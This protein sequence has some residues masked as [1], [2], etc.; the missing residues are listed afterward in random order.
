MNDLPR[1]ILEY[2]RQHLKKQISPGKG[3]FMNKKIKSIF[4]GENCV[5]GGL[6]GFA[7]MTD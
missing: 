5:L 6:K 2:R 7:N 3:T 1:N 4:L